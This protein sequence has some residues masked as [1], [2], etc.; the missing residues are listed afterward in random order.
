MTDC[1]GDLHIL[2]D[3]QC[4]PPTFRQREGPAVALSQ[5]SHEKNQS[6][7][8]SLLCSA[9]MYH[10]PHFSLWG[11]YSLSAMVLSFGLFS[12]L[13]AIG[14]PMMVMTGTSTNLSA[15]SS[16]SP[17]TMQPGWR[18][19][20]PGGTS[21]SAACGYLDGDTTIGSVLTMSIQDAIRFRGAD[22]GICGGQPQIRV[23]SW[24][25]Q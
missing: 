7:W 9:R 11:H 5:V 14:L 23:L 25:G 17:S 16:I 18:N 1:Q 15:V 10:I 13:I 8:Y 19:Y 21:T 20:S 3:H 22:G 24:D 4:R 2:E 6:I 12:P